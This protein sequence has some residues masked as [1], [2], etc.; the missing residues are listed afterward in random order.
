MSAVC[1]THCL[2]V[3][4]YFQRGHQTLWRAGEKAVTESM[5]VLMAAAADFH[6]QHICHPSCAWPLWSF[7]QSLFQ[8]MCRSVSFAVLL[9]LLASSNNIP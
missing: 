9:D 1:P 8:F 6:A 5:P 7:V 3:F 2:H 4:K